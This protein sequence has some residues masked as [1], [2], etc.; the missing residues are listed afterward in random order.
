MRRPCAAKLRQSSAFILSPSDASGRPASALRRRCGP[1]A[2][3]ASLVPGE[4]TIRRRGHARRSCVSSR[5]A[6][7]PPA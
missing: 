4:M 7:R 6:S 5:G 1:C 3:H 2:S